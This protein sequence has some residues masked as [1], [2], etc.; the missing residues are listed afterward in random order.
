[1]FSKTKNEGSRKHPSAAMLPAEGKEQYPEYRQAGKNDE[2]A[3]G[4]LFVQNA[5]C[6]GRA[7]LW[8]SSFEK[9]A[10]S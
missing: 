3:C 8:I 4:L 2:A 9:C 6:T 7:I 1:M 5:L 10:I